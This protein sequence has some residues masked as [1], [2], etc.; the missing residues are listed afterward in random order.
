MGG[1]GAGVLQRPPVCQVERSSVRCGVL[2]RRVPGRRGRFCCILLGALCHDNHVTLFT[3]L[4]DEPDDH[5]RFGT[6]YS[7]SQP[8]AEP[9]KRTSLGIY[10]GAQCRRSKMLPKLSTLKIQSSTRMYIKGYKPLTDLEGELS[11]LSVLFG[12]NTVGKSNFLDASQLLS[13]LA[14]S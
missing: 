3:A 6:K 12:P 10:G 14:T 11:P 13:K 7:I 4:A 8:I 9:L 2:N 1:Q 5:T